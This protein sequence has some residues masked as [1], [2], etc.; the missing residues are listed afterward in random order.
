MRSEVLR[1]LE[2][3]CV[4]ALVGIGVFFLRKHGWTRVYMDIH[5]HGWGYFVASVL[6]AIVA[7][8][9]YFYWTHRLLHLPWLYRYV[10]AVH[11]RSKNPIPWAAFA[12]HPVEAFVHAAIVPVLLVTIPFNP[13]AI[14]AF[15]LYMTGMNVLGHLG[16]ELYPA[17]AVRHAFGKWH[18]TATHHNQHHRKPR[19][20]FGLYFN[21]WDRILRTNHADYLNAF[22]RATGCV[23]ES[24]D[25][26]SSR[27]RPG[28]YWRRIFTTAGTPRGT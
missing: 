7:H 16:F 28:A 5:R 26:R 23:H 6:F 27:D 10:H 8:D 1:S 13:W 14:F 24:S 15:L 3:F 19:G 25:P 9:T 17:G 11:H 21:A 18:N 4:F 22:D 12:F 20:N 2:T